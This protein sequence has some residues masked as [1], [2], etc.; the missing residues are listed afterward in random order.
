MKKKFIFSKMQFY[1]LNTNGRKMFC[2]EGCDNCDHVSTCD[3]GA[4]AHTKFCCDAGGC[5]AASDCDGG[6]NCDYN[7]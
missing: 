5:D 3:A 4:Q 7:A 6:S 2:V 1:A